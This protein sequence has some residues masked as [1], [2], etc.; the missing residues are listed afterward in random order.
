MGLGELERLVLV[1]GVVER[2]NVVRGLLVRIRL[3]RQDVVWCFMDGIVVVRTDVVGPYVVRA[4]VERGWVVLGDLGRLGRTIRAV[5][6][7]VVEHAVGRL[8]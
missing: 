4:H 3:G 5:R 7:C 8:T 2:P 1:W 6:R